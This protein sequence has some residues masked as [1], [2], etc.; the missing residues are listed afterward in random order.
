MTIEQSKEKLKKEGYTWF[1]LNEFDSEF[2]NWL[3]PLKCD[4][5]NNLKDKITELRIDMVKHALIKNASIKEYNSTT[6]S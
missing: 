1:E 6:Y 2:H 5:Q 4:E 3:Q